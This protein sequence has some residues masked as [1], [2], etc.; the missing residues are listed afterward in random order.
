[1]ALNNTFGIGWRLTIWYIQLNE[2]SMCGRWIKPKKPFIQHSRSHPSKVDTSAVIT[3]ITDSLTLHHSSLKFSF[4]YFLLCCNLTLTLT[5]FT[6]CTNGPDVF[7][8]FW[9]GKMFWFFSFATFQLT[10]KSKF[11]RNVRKDDD[12][13]GDADE[14]VHG[15]WDENGPNARGVRGRKEVCKLKVSLKF[16]INLQCQLNWRNALGWM[17]GKSF[18]LANCHGKW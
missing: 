18:I 1:M 10:R 3:F 12:G 7:W 11:T 15:P 16:T 17:N 5:I 4:R 13:H 9:L 8:C 14:D 6:N 2:Q